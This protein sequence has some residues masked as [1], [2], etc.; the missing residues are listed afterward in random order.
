MDNPTIKKQFFDL[1]NSSLNLLISDLSRIRSS[2]LDQYK[3]LELENLITKLK[4]NDSDIVIKYININYQYKNNI[5]IREQR[6][7]LF[8]LKEKLNNLDYKNT[9]EFFLD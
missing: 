3:N 6:L 2:V 7:I 8:G 5:E 4:A 9:E 1:T